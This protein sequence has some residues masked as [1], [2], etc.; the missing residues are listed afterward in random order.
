MTNYLEIILTEGILYYENCNGMD[1]R[2]ISRKIHEELIKKDLPF[3][4]E[5]RGAYLK[6]NNL[7]DIYWIYNAELFSDEDARELVMKNVNKYNI[8]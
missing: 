2:T 4:I 6:S 8:N 1:S 7:V 5:K 3:E